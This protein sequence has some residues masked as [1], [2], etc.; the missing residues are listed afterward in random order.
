MKLNFK[1]HLIII[2]LSLLSVKLFSEIDT[3]HDINADPGHNGTPG[4]E[5]KLINNDTEYEVSGG[6]AY[7]ETHIVIP[8]T[9]NGKPVTKIADAV[10]AGHPNQLFAG[11]FAEFYSMISIS[12]PNSITVIGNAAFANCFF[13]TDIIIPNSVVK[14]GSEAF[15]NC[16]KLTNIIIP[17]SV[18]GSIGRETFRFCISL[19]NVIFEQPSNIT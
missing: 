8:D 2:M 12:I 4:L 10:K 16:M 1:I 3:V 15:I 17:S 7:F 6:T 13:L 11:G 18:M 9:Y 19:K 14:I 5:F